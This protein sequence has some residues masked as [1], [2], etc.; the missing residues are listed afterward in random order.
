M[1]D[2]KPDKI[3]KLKGCFYLFWLGAISGAFS[4]GI[5]LLLAQGLF[6]SGLVG[7]QQSGSF[8]FDLLLASFGAIIIGMPSGGIGG[9]IVGSIW[10]NDRAPIIGGIIVPL[11]LITI[12]TILFILVPCPFLG[13]C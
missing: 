13:G 4:G 8:I 6:R 11:V 7:N 2:N 1:T 10:K 9:L 5:S 3:E 12:L